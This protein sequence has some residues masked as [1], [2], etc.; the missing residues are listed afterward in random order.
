[1]HCLSQARG[2][3]KRDS[4]PS[5]RLFKRSSAGRL[6]AAV[7][8]PTVP[9]LLWN[10]K[11]NCPLPCL[12][13]CQSVGKCRCCLHVA[14]G[15]T[16]TVAFSLPAFCSSSSLLRPSLA[17]PLFRLP[18]HSAALEWNGKSARGS[19]TEKGSKH[20]TARRRRRCETVQCTATCATLR[21]NSISRN[22]ETQSLRFLFDTT[23]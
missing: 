22:T 9:D 16:R 13:V 1:M 18:F 5:S 20:G 11:R 14:V 3:R 15:R 21:V 19:Q 12:S 2:G 4:P 6:S 7:S 8:A 23:V 17:P 10:L